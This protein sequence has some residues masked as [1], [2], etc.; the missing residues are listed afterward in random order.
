MCC[1]LSLITHLLGVFQTGVPSLLLQ[2]SKVPP[3]PTFPNVPVSG[4]LEL[5][6]TQQE[7][8]PVV[9]VALP[10]GGGAQ[11]PSGRAAFIPQDLVDGGA[12]LVGQGCRVGCRVAVFLGVWERG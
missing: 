5:A 3:H 9:R 4:A 2:R 1:C 6:G 10:A 12:V 8:G 11:A 7:A